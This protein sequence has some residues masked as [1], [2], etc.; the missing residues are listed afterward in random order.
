MS[1]T[2]SPTPPW[3]YAEMVRLLPLSAG[4]QDPDALRPRLEAALLA[5][6]RRALADA[7]REEDHD[8]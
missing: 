8:G 7:K 4:L 6:Y 2:L 1:P 5:A 3:L